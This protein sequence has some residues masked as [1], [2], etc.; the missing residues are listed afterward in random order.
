MSFVVVIA[1]SE[2]GGARTTPLLSL[3]LFKQK[4]IK[5]KRNV[6]N[7][8]F[9]DR[10]FLCLLMI[11]KILLYKDYKMKINEKYPKPKFTRIRKTTNT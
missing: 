4:L 10:I 7:R 5:N 6:V 8:V 11:K 2:D 1:L 3:R 9:G